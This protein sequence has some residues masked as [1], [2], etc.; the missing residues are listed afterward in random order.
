MNH[1]LQD[2][3]HLIEREIHSY[4]TSLLEEVQRRAHFILIFVAVRPNDNNYD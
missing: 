4:M 2:D 1:G 3:R